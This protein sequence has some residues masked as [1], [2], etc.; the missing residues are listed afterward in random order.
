MSIYIK[1]HLLNSKRK[2]A[3]A[4]GLSLGLHLLIVVTL[5]A[6]AE[7]EAL[8]PRT[9]VMI[10]MVEAAKP[11]PK[12]PAEP[13]P[14]PKPRPKP[15]PKP[16]PKPNLEP[17]PQ[18]QAK[19]EPVLEKEP[20]PVENTDAL[21]SQDTQDEIELPQ[22]QADYLQNPPPAYPRLSQR[23]KEQGEVLLRVRVGVD[24]EPLEISLQQT[25]GHARLDQAAQKAVT[26]WRF[27]PAQSNGKP[28]VAWVVVPFEF[29][30]GG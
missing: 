8:T 27:E 30:L 18:V 9:V 20:E 26:Q 23:L 29:T 17:E 5:V 15:Q 22:F 28:V 11:A 2:Q 3:L 16:E 10:S 6:Q 13:E 12:L 14:K 4:G 19:P 24:G 1:Q 7:P 25:S 21:A